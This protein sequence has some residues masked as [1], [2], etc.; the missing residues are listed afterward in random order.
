MNGKVEIPLDEFLELLNFKKEVK[1]EDIFGEEKLFSLYVSYDGNI[2]LQ[3]EEEIL[4][5][6]AKEYAE[7][8]IAKN[9]NLGQ[10]IKKSLEKQEWTSSRL[11]YGSDLTKPK[12]NA[13]EEK[14]D[15]LF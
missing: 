11:Y 9:T 13:Q 10:K 2:S 12:V 3:C 8:Q 7:K 6:F 5:K 14:E 15:D 4:L 1:P